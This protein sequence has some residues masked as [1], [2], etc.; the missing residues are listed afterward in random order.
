MTR[1]YPPPVSPSMCPQPPGLSIRSPRTP[2]TDE[3]LPALTTMP[4]PCSR[5]AATPDSR[6]LPVMI[7]A[8][9]Q[10]S[11]QSRES[12]CRSSAVPHPARK[13]PA[14]SISRGS[15]RKIAFRRYGDC[16][17]KFDGGSFPWPITPK[18]ASV[19]SPRHQALFVPPPSTPRILSPS[20]AILYAYL[21][22]QY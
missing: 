20:F 8:F 10:I 5:A 22:L 6:S 11:A 18:V 9:G 21:L 2:V 3:P 16:K 14:R 15:S 4:S 13:T 7:L 12:D 17:R 1:E 19:R